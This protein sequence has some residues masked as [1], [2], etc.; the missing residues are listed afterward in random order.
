MRRR[1]EEVFSSLC[2]LLNILPVWGLVF[3][4]GLWY[5]FREESRRV[6]YH[7]RQAILFHLPLM[8]LLLVWMLMG[9]LSRILQVVFPG[10]GVILNNFNNWIMGGCYLV[11][12][13]I[14]LWGFARTL[15]GFPFQYPLVSVKE[16]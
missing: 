8:V 5:L 11:Y 10:V 13:A 6:I 2:H 12:L 4:G 1:Q 14:C 16:P 3:C 15:S 7:A 9:L